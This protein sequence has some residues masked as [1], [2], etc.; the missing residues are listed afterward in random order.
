MTSQTVILF[1]FLYLLLHVLQDYNAQ[2]SDFGLA[3]E[4]P[5]GDET[6]VSTQVVGTEGYAAPEYVTTGK[7]S[8]GTMQAIQNIFVIFLMKSSLK[9]QLIKLMRN[10][11]LPT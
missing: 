5:M 2:L 1:P 6:H 8:R 10:A 7:S 4:G 9:D 3:K 11:S